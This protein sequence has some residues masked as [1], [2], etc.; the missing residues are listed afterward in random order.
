M[1]INGITNDEVACRKT[2]QEADVQITVKEVL[3]LAFTI[4]TK[5][6]ASLEDGINLNLKFATA[7]DAKSARAWIAD[8]SKDGYGNL[9]WERAVHKARFSSKKFVVG[10][11]CEEELVGLLSGDID[12]DK[13]IV[14]LRQIE[15]DGSKGSFEGRAIPFAS[16]LMYTISEVFELDEIRILEPAKGLLNRYKEFFNDAEEIKNRPPYLRVPVY[17]LSS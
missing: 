12:L 7:E 13:K 6:Y 14:N 4:A 17:K 11:H 16:R 3:E 10:V 1:F 2:S 9:P 15:R 8:K 5:E